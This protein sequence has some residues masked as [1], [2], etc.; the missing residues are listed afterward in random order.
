MNLFT[1]PKQIH[2]FKKQTYGYQ[3]GNV[4]GRDKLEVWDEPRHATTHKIDNQQGPLVQYRDLYSISC[5]NLY[6]KRI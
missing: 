6:G 3:S 4:V 2:K 1:T 5:N